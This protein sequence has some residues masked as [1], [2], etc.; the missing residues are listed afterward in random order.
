LYIYRDEV[1][2]DGKK[3]QIEIRSY[4]KEAHKTDLTQ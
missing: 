2:I 4:G 3:E 1:E